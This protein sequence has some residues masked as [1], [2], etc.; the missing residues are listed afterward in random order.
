MEEK[1][2]DTKQNFIDPLLILKAVP[3]NS[4]SSSITSLC[5]LSHAPSETSSIVVDYPDEEESDASSDDEEFEAHFQNAHRGNRDTFLAVQRAKSRLALDQTRLVTC[6]FEGNALIWDVGKSTVLGELVDKSRGPGLSVKRIQHDNFKD[7]ALQIM[8]H[9]R[10][11]QGTVSLHDPIKSD[12]I[13]SIHTQSHTFCAAA[14]CTGDHHLVAL[15]S[16]NEAE[17]VIRDW[18]VDPSSSPVA[19]FPGAGVFDKKHGMLTSLNM[20]YDGNRHFVCCGMEDGSLYYHDLSRVDRK[21]DECGFSLGS[22]PILALDTSPSPGQQKGSS[23]VCLAGLAGAAEELCNIP[24]S[25]RGRIAILKVSQRNGNLWETRVRKRLATAACKPG[26]AVCR[27]RQDGKIFAAG[28]WDKRVR[29]FHRD[30]RALAILKGHD[31][32]IQAVD[33]SPRSHLDGLLASGSSDG[34]VCIWQ[35]YGA[36]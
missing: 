15:P 9:T 14:P 33:W 30:G 7:D 29:I 2:S 12:A 28:G 10:D 19:A 20:V 24:E 16:G 13:V 36:N 17:V 5:F 23:F 31:K 8:Y 21:R 26:V 6:D 34:R 1:V 22:D 18:R 27:F 25:D 35:C 11:P 4:A 32:G 3:H